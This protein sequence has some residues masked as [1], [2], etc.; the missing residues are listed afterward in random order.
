M[1]AATATRKPVIPAPTDRRMVNA[2]VHTRLSVGLDDFTVVY[3]YDTTTETSCAG[4]TVVSF[5]FSSA[6]CTGTAA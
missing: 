6:T 5:S 2:A 4:K 3:A 1:T